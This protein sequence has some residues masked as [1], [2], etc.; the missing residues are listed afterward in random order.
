MCEPIFR[1][2]TFSKWCL[3]GRATNRIIVKCFGHEPNEWTLRN[4]SSDLLISAYPNPTNSV[5]T[6]SLNGKFEGEIHVI[7]T[8]MSGRTLEQLYKGRIEK[9]K[10]TFDVNLDSFDKGFI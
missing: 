4:N 3:L 5:T 7:L 6:I 8:D 1:S 2:C 10:R 9:Q